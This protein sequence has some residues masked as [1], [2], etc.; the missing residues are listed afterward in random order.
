MKYRA[1]GNRGGV[2]NYRLC[3]RDEESRACASSSGLRR[4]VV[5]SA[6]P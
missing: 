2:V 5:A 1:T 3:L 6:T 4:A